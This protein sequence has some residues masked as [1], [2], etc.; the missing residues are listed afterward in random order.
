MRIARNRS[1][2]R[3]N[4][5]ACGGRQRRR[6]T[7]FIYSMPCAAGCA[8]G[9]ATRAAHTRRTQCHAQARAPQGPKARG[10]G[11]R[12]ARPR[13]AV[14]TCSRVCTIIGRGTCRLLQRRARSKPQMAGYAHAAHRCQHRHAIVVAAP[15]PDVTTVTRMALQVELV[16]EAGSARAH[17]CRQHYEFG[18]LLC[19]RMAQSAERRERQ[20]PASRAGGQ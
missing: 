1:E 17:Q 4:W 18:P 12:Q 6:T 11:R 9:K 2:L 19:A 14:E 5:T 15:L 20:Q 16:D 10:A 13:P 7:A 8:C 3:A